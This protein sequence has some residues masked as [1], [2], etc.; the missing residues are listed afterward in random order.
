MGHLLPH[1]SGPSGR[2][3]GQPQWVQVRLDTGAR[4]VS[5]PLIRV[6]VIKVKPKPSP[7]SWRQPLCPGWGWGVV[8]AAA[9]VPYGAGP[10]KEQGRGL[11]ASDSPLLQDQVR[12]SPHDIQGPPWGGLRLFFQHSPLH[13]R[14]HFEAVELPYMD[15]NKVPLKCSWGSGFGWQN[16][17]L[18]KI[19]KI[20]HSFFLV[21][22]HARVLSWILARP[23]AMQARR[24]GQAHCSPDGETG[25]GGGSSWPES[26][27]PGHR[28][29]NSAVA[30]YFTP[31]SSWAAKR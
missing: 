24:S 13:P 9:Q 26:H 17:V 21:T 2:L 14:P 8:A 15:E 4:A 6:G 30:S 22:T 31:G 1:A 19:R 11:S 27:R 25:Q 5:A 3:W 20:K 7:G 16:N 12:V 28:T 23:L 10:G 18:V 29:Q